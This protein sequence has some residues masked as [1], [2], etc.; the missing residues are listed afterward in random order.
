MSVASSKTTLDAFSFFD[1]L[2]VICTVFPWAVICGTYLRFRPAV[3]KQR[4]QGRIPLEAISPL[5][6]YLAIYGL[7]VSSMLGNCVVD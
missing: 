4:L 2:T 7:F 5:Q 1:E 3:K 6:P